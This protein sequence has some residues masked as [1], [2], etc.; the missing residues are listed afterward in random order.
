LI[1]AGAA[2]AADGSRLAD[3]YTAKTAAMTPSG[4]MVRIDVRTWSDDAARAAVIEALTTSSGADAVKALQ[5][6]PTV[7][8]VW[9]G[10]SPVGYAL[11]YA[12]RVATT[13]GERL[14]FLT[15]KR[16]GAYDRKPWS[17]EPT[18]PQNEPTYSLIELYLDRSGKGDGTLSLAPQPNLDKEQ[19][20]VTFATDAPRVLVEAKHEPKDAAKGR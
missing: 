17:V 15:D 5:V 11:K 1:A 14:T 4:V 16:L 6:L 19:G 12:H 8:Y 3:R 18:E 7:G 2:H 13:D 10:D 9:Q 20:I